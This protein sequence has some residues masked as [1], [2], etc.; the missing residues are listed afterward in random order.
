MIPGHPV[1]QS[2]SVLMSV[3][4][5]LSVY[6]RLL[7]AVGD[8]VGCYLLL[9]SG[10]VIDAVN[11]I[12]GIYGAVAGGDKRRSPALL[13][14][15]EEGQFAGAPLLRASAGSIDH[16]AVRKVRRVRNKGCAHLDS[17][18]KLTQITSMVIDLE[19]E[20]LVERVLKPAWAA[21]HEACAADITTRWLLMD[22]ASLSALRPIST[23]GVR[24][25]DRGAA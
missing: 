12:D 4:D 9:K 20:V 1:Q 11:L 5:T 7:N 19:H 22:E 6:T 18:M 16:G 14:I 23:P 3:I 21:V 24:A 17:W 15:L 13:E 2:A 10:Y 8:D 25:F